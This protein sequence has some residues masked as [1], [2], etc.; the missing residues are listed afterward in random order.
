MQGEGQTLLS[1]LAIALTAAGIAWPALVPVHDT[2]R[3]AWVGVAAVGQQSVFLSTDGMPAVRLAKQPPN[4]KQART[5]ARPSD[6]HVYIPES[7]SDC[8]L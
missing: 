2:L 6:T 7:A 1:A 8:V 4:L 3:D 5:A